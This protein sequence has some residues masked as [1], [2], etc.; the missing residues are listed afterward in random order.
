M[1]TRSQLP[2]HTIR[3]PCACSLFK[4]KGGAAQFLA[5]IH[6]STFRRLLPGKQVVI[7]LAVILP[8]ISIGVRFPRSFQPF[9][10]RLRPI[11][12]FPNARIRRYTDLLRPWLP[13]LSVES[14]RLIHR[15]VFALGTLPNE[16]LARDTPGPRGK[17]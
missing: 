15:F 17:E 14:Y 12:N 2:A 3:S 7:D 11:F 13:N 8:W 10:I 6:P 1:S 4:E 5:E 16:L 9:F